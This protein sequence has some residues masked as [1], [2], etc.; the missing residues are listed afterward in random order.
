MSLKL[1]TSLQAEES[2]LSR[3]KGNRPARHYLEQSAISPISFSI[4]LGGVGL[5]CLLCLGAEV[6]RGGTSLE[7]AGEEWLQERVEHN[8]STAILAVRRG[9]KKTNTRHYLGILPS[10]GKGHP[11]DKNKLE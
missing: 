6:G 8:L 1:S 4:S 9:F 3:W 5:G 10:L 2:P 11:K 7:V